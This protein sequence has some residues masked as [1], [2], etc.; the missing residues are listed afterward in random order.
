MPKVIVELGDDSGI[1]STQA[2]IAFIWLV[3]PRNESG[4]DSLKVLYS[5]RAC[6]HCVVAKIFSLHT[7][8]I[9][10]ELSPKP[11]SFIL[12][13]IHYPSVEEGYFIIF[14]LNVWK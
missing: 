8:I 9:G 6:Y 10:I 3:S 1:Y 13:M 5:I 7:W 14:R 12:C 4:Y 11:K 2:P